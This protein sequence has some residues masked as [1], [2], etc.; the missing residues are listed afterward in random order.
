MFSRCRLRK[1]R[2]DGRDPC[3]SCLRVGVNCRKRDISRKFYVPQAYVEELEQRVKQTKSQDSQPIVEDLEKEKPPKRQNAQ[4]VLDDSAFLK[5]DFDDNK[6]DLYFPAMQETNDTDSTED[7]KLWEESFITVY[8]GA[9]RLQTYDLHPDL[10]AETVQRRRSGFRPTGL[11][12]DL[13]LTV[14]AMNTFE[15]HKTHKRYEMRRLLSLR[16]WKSESDSY[17]LVFAIVTCLFL[18]LSFLTSYFGMD[19]E[20]VRTDEATWSYSTCTIGIGGLLGAGSILPLLR[21]GRSRFKITFPRLSIPGVLSVQIWL[22]NTMPMPLLRLLRPNVRHGRQRLEWKCTCG[23]AMYGDYAKHDTMQN[24]SLSQYLPECRIVDATADAPRTLSNVPARTEEILKP[25]SRKNIVHGL[26][27]WKLPLMKV[28]NREVG[29]GDSSQD[30]ME[31]RTT[32]NDTSD[33]SS[34]PPGSHRDAQSA[35]S[36]R[37]LSM[38]NMSNSSNGTASE[39]V[40]KISERSSSRSVFEAKLC[41]AMP[42]FFELCV[43]GSKTRVSLG[44]I[45]IRDVQGRFCINTDMQLFSKSRH[46]LRIVISNRYLCRIPE[47]I[48]EE[49]NRLRR[50]GLYTWLYRPNN[51]HFVRFGVHRGGFQTG[52]YE[53]PLAVPPA[54]EVNE[55]RYHYYECPLDPLPPIDPGTFFHYFWDHA[56]HPESSGHPGFDTLFFNRLPKKLGDSILKQADPGKL[57]LGWGVHIIEGP[58]KPLLAWLATGILVLSFITSLVYDVVL[59]NRESGFAIG[60]WIVAVLGTALT[61]MYFHLADLV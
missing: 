24:A 60:Q 56:S 10:N 43:N 47:T 11:R 61:A 6:S 50:K 14:P 57:Q 2:C 13:K 40:G 5:F 27:T 19:L 45:A 33:T 38:S 48:N 42:A 37:N 58:N 59:K 20:H 4:P 16:H 41:D 3:S 39:S 7:F 21:K 51:I 30:S 46:C 44:E 34:A 28:L 36:S 9:N 22:H 53:K 18:P 31:H 1:T 32:Q 29:S 15:K 23:R 49:Y 26:L 55:Q 54:E 12:S 8:L 35:P 25:R 52:I 17:L